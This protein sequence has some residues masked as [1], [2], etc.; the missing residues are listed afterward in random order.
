MSGAE[1]LT[2]SARGG[3]FATRGM[4]ARC[5]AVRGGGI[6]L[7]LSNESLRFRCIWY[8]PTISIIKRA[9]MQSPDAAMASIK[10]PSST[11]SMSGRINTLPMYDDVSNARG[12]RLHVQAQ[13]CTRLCCC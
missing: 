6:S 10:V 5:W 9:N 4:A 7:R 3:I 13:R 11:A 8:L 1:G 2:Q 12:S